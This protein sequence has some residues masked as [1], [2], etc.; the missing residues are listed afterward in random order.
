MN[1]LSFLLLLFVLN[2][3]CNCATP[4]IEADEKA[5][6]DSATLLE[7]ASKNFSNG[8]PINYLELCT[9]YKLALL[10]KIEFCGDNDGEIQNTLDNL[11]ECDGSE[12]P[13]DCPSREAAVISA[14]KDFEGANTLN[15]SSLCNSYVLALE[16]LLISCGD[17]TGAIQLKIDALGNCEN[18]GVLIKKITKTETNGTVSVIDYKYDGTKLST[19]LNSNGN[20]KTFTYEEEKV[21]RIDVEETN[22]SGMLTYYIEL[23]YDGEQL[24]STTKY[25]T[26]INKAEKN[27]YV[28]NPD[29][30]ITESKYTG[31]LTSQTNLYSETVITYS[32]GNM[33]TSYA[34]FS[35]TVLPDFEQQYEYSLENSIYRNIKGS[36]I[37]NIIYKAD[38]DVNIQTKQTYNVGGIEN[39]NNNASFVFNDDDYPISGTF[40]SGSSVY[41]EDYAY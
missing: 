14:A 24:L 33:V 15:Y 36:A 11:G 13:T 22:S 31:D 18:D 4:P 37:L 23:N 26:S 21:T 1:K 5:C 35:D 30:T 20:S 40:N 10:N 9:N 34:T 41:N 17:N 6:I 39:F 27:E 3:V 25:E 29:G 19:I 7:T 12:P 32:N 2:T 28:Y 38:Y 8:T 16:N